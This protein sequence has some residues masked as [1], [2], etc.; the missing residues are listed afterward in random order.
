MHDLAESLIHLKRTLRGEVTD[1]PEVISQASFDFGR[2]VRRKPGLVVVPNDS[3]DISTL[4]RYANRHRI[5]VSTQG[6]S[7]TQ[8]GHSL[9]AGGIVLQTH[10]LNSIVDI[11]AA[12]AWALVESGVRWSDLVQATLERGYIPPVLTTNLHTT[13]GGTHSVGGVGF[14]SFRYGSQ[15]DICLGIEVVL[16]SGEAVWCSP[17]A[18]EQLFHHA[19][20]G[21][22]QFGV[23]TQ[24]KIP[25][26][27]FKA[28]TG[29]VTILHDNA[30]ELIDG[31][32]RMMS[33]ECPNMV[34]LSGLIETG[35]AGRGRRIPGNL[36]CIL[37]V[38]VESETCDANRNTLVSTL[39]D[40][41][42]RVTKTVEHDTETLL[43]SD[44]GVR[45]EKSR[46]NR[47]QVDPG[48]HCILPS[49]NAR[50][51]IN[52]ILY[53]FSQTTT[54]LRSVEYYLLPAYSRHF[55]K[56]LFK[57]PDDEVVFIFGCSPRWA[58]S[59]W[60]KYIAL[61]AEFRDRVESGNGNHYLIGCTGFSKA[62]WMAHYGESWSALNRLKERYDP[63]RILNADFIAYDEGASE[64]PKGNSIG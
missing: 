45:L 28:R 10:R 47:L 30:D 2:V 29:I 61:M 3:Q 18:N 31:V 13:V 33:N 19:L 6:A 51:T 15:A 34:G 14:G 9:N 56:P 17:S 1:A 16:P 55:G 25:V 50:Q 7:H 60:Q 64:I 42:S 24:L 37:Q 36:R 26:R 44:L 27:K 49:G 63:N 54:G 53:C 4:F 39:A 59:D 40:G 43:R 38:A 12:E 5:S 20:C 22:G 52:D 58:R 48:F 8:G 41:N 46:W 62:E 11:N 35:P 57:V 21:L 23:I 32:E